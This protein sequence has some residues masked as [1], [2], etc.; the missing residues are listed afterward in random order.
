MRRNRFLIGTSYDVPE[1]YN[2]YGDFLTIKGWHDAEQYHIR[3][4]GPYDDRDMIING[5]RV[6]KRYAKET[7]DPLPTLRLIGSD[8]DGNPLKIV[9]EGKNEYWPGDG[10]TWIDGVMVDPPGTHDDFERLGIPEE[11]REAINGKA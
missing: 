4:P 6:S 7:D 10:S 5:E 9:I 2:P 3:F 11:L 1:P 8:A